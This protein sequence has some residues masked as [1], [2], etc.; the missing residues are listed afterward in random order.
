MCDYSL[1]GVASRPAAVGDK[2]TTRNFGTG[3]RGFAA[4]E[5]RNVAVCVLPGTEIAFANE[6][7][8]ESPRFF[9]QSIKTLKHR[10]AIFRQI[11]KDTPH[12]HHD[13]LE[14]PDGQIVLL[15]ALRENQE[16]AILQLPARP[17]TVREA[18]EQRRVA[19]TG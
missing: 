6:V 8:V 14:F 15:T 7:A 2:L 4:A 3:T 16:A 10:T 11:D 19:Y 9:G 17:T 5:D 12:V 18:E 1:Q 13:A